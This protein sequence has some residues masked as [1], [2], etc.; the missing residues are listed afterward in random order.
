MRGSPFIRLLA[1][2]AVMA[3]MGIPLR[4]LT[5]RRVAAAAPAPAQPQAESAVHLEVTATSGPFEFVV[6]NLGNVIWKGETDGK[7]VTQDVKLP[8]PPEGIELGLEGE[9]KGAPLPAAVKLAVTP[10]N[11]STLEKVVWAN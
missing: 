10:E 9:F 6:K 3:L 7:P 11:G 2:L 4:Q 8:L 1:I 5:T